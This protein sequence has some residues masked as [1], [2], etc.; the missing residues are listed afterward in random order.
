MGQPRQFVEGK[1]KDQISD[2]M[3]GWRSSW[4]ESE[5][6]REEKRREEKKRDQG[7]QDK[8]SRERVRKK[9]MQVREKVEKSAIHCV[10]PMACGSGGS[11]NR[12]AK[13]AG[14]EP[15]G[16]MRH[17]ELYASVAQSTFGSQNQRWTTFGS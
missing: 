10:F 15:F 16:Q 5:K 4:E 3:D 14:A 8:E 7:R 9:K 6:R 1:F 2:N 17:E 13:A 11:K 12:F